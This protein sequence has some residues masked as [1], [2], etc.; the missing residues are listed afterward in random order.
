MGK[1]NSLPHFL[2]TM[3]TCTTCQLEFDLRGVYNTHTRKCIP[4]STF[5]THTGQQVTVTRNR[6]GV[7]LCY[8]SNPSCPKPTGYFTTDTMKKHMKKVQST[9]I[10]PNKDKQSAQLKVNLCIIQSATVFN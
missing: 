7:F 9:W 4:V 10:G 5:T 2:T 1:Y 8:C 6:N 3:F